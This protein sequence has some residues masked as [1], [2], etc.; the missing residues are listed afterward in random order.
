MRSRI[1]GRYDFFGEEKGHFGKSAG[2]YTNKNVH[3]QEVFY[4]FYELFHLSK[5]KTERLFEGS[6]TE[7]HRSS[8]AFLQWNCSFLRWNSVELRLKTFLNDNCGGTGG[9]GG[10]NL[11]TRIKSQNCRWNYRWNFGKSGGTSVEL[12]WN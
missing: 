11:L 6:S 12:R 2:D 9:T 10:T 1:G 7:F 3:V 5:D 4:T 8:T